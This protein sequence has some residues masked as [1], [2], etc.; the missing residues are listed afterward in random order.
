MLSALVLSLVVSAEP[1]R[2]T[3]N[4]QEVIKVGLV[5]KIAIGDPQVADITPM[6]KGE[7]LITARQKGRTTIMLWTANGIQKRDVIVDDGK[8]SEL[9]KLIKSTINPSLTVGEFNGTTVIDGTLDSTEELRRLR[10]LIGDDANVKILA[11]LDP[12]VLPAVAQ[13]IN[14]ALLR[15]GIKTAKVNVVGSILMLEGSVADE[16]EMRKAQLIADS[17]AGMALKY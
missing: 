14:A 10:T 12:R 15:E 9:G 3:P 2:M 17:F 8:T 6:A 7:L 16:R 13:N 11:K 1:V 4:S 5:S